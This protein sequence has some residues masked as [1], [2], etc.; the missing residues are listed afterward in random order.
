MQLFKKFQYRAYTTWSKSPQPLTY[1]LQKTAWSGLV[2]LESPGRGRGKV[3]WGSII[4]ETEWRSNGMKNC[5][6]WYLGGGQQLDC[7]KKNVW[8]RL[9]V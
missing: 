2:R 6:R 9:E 8:R 7:F 1:I 3:L 5:G 4:S